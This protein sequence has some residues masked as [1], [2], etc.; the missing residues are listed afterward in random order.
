MP[1]RLVTLPRLIDLTILVCH[2]HLE[3][4]AK[5]AVGEQRSISDSGSV[6]RVPVSL[7]TE[8]L[9][10]ESSNLASTLIPRRTL[11]SLKT[12]TL[13]LQPVGLLLDF[14]GHSS[15]IIICPPLRSNL[16]LRELLRRLDASDVG[17][18]ARFAF[19][20]GFLMGTDIIN[21]SDD[22]DDFDYYRVS[23]IILYVL[24]RY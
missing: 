8:P 19:V 6:V 3:M 23:I 15:D 18:A 20:P 9:S 14:L 11:R 1:G 22:Y 7:P 12:N 16:P 2:Q 24:Y 13:Q 17:I 4:L 5:H 21:H 10:I